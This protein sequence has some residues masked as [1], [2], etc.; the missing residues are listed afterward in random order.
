MKRL[1]I[2]VLCAPGFLLAG[3]RLDAAAAT[4]VAV[5]PAPPEATPAPDPAEEEF[6]GGPNLKALAA[7]KLPPNPT[8]E[9]VLEYIDDILRAS[10]HQSTWTPVDPQVEMLARLGPEH[11]D[12]LLAAAR[13]PVHDYYLMFA[14][15][16]IVTDEHKPVIL[17]A[18]RRHNDLV[19]TVIAKGWQRD[20]RGVLLEKL[21]SRPDYLP[22]EWL[23][24]V[25]SL[26][27]P[28]SYPGLKDYL[29]HGAN[30]VSTYA[31]IRELPG[32][33]LEE[34]VA[35]AWAH[36]KQ[37]IGRATDEFAEVAAGYGH[38]DALVRLFKRLA[39]PQ[40]ARN[41]FFEW[42]RRTVRDKVKELVGRTATDA[43]QVEW[44]KA[45]RDRLR[46]D[47]EA[48]K[49]VVAATIRPAGPPG[50]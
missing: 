49:W 1:L 22:S 18:M 40:P 37:Q 25:V 13:D 35:T 29:V 44:F 8:R 39:E 2:S 4:R 48:K 16:R 38:F 30:P 20:A 21:N 43:E 27:E 10:R 50:R 28:E 36:R 47:P 34:W 32:I 3:P 5:Q 45:H 15:E 31:V 24:A 26:N 12:V 6:E 33:D 17:H 11:L 14:I 42:E 19:R 46:W 41:Q 7:I 23:D 9:Q